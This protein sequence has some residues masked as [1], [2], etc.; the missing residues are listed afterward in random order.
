VDRICTHK[1]EGVPH[2]IFQSIS[3]GDIV[4][5]GFISKEFP[6]PLGIAIEIPYH[7]RFF[8]FG[9]RGSIARTRVKG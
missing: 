9:I 1:Y 8:R 7:A 3:L 4:A 6:E 5:P 2:V